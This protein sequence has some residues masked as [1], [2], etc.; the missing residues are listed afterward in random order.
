VTIND[1][2]FLAPRTGERPTLWATDKVSGTFAGSPQIGIP[3]GMT[4]TGGSNA[5][6]VNANFTV[7]NW[8]QTS[9]GATINGNGNVGG[10]AVNFNGAGAGSVDLLNNT[11]NGTGAGTTK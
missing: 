2:T 7:K 11:F 10:H 9:W 1:M 5:S 8:S 4:Q 3:V 6:N